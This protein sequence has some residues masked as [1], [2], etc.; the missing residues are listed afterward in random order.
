MKPEKKKPASSS[1][2]TGNMIC[3]H[4]GK[5]ADDGQGIDGDAMPANGDFSVCAHCGGF[6]RFVISKRKYSLAK[7]TSDSLDRA[8][9]N[10]ALDQVDVLAMHMAARAV[11]KFGPPGKGL[12]AFNAD[13]VDRE[14]RKERGH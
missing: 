10:G 3:P 9:R 7:A 6:V 12:A 11:A 14:I 1:K 13:A 8:V 2:L 4:C 5:R